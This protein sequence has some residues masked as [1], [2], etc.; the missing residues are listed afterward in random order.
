MPVRRTRVPGQ[1]PGAYHLPIRQIAGV[2]QPVARADMLA[3]AGV[4][5]AKPLLAQ[6]TMIALTRKNVPAENV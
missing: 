2:H 4:G 1:L 5:C 6:A 3:I